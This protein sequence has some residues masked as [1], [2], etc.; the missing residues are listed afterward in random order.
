MAKLHYNHVLMVEPNENAGFALA[1]LIATTNKKHSRLKDGTFT[2][3]KRFKEARHIT[4][5][6]DFSHDQMC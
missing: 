1:S 5:D 4:T 2:T 3:G 6:F